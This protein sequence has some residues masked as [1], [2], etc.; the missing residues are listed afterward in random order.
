MRI[1][2][3]TVLLQ[4]TLAPVPSE[5]QDKRFDYQ[6]VTEKVK[7]DLRELCNKLYLFP[8]LGAIHVAE[9]FVLKLFDTSSQ[10]Q[11]PISSGNYDLSSFFYKMSEVLYL[12]TEKSPIKEDVKF[13]QTLYKILNQY[14]F[15]HYIQQKSKDKKFLEILSLPRAYDLFIAYLRTFLDLTASNCKHEIDIT[16]LLDCEEGFVS[17]IENLKRD[18]K[19]KFDA[20]SIKNLCDPNT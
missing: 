18:L 12:K 10:T 9:K 3:F 6:P 20:Y 8:E 15:S 16:K 2:I 14:N 17:V 4:K 13:Y 5:A 11:D 19:E 1:S 7:Y